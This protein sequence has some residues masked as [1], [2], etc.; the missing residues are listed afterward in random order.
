VVLVNKAHGRSTTP[1]PLPGLTLGFE[2]PGLS[3]IVDAG[4]RR[5]AELSDRAGA[6]VAEVTMAPDRKRTPA[7]PTDFYWSK[8]PHR[9][10][11]LLGA[12]FVALEEVAKG[13]YRRNRRRPL[14]AR[15]VAERARKRPRRR[16]L[17]AV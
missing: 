12:L 2:F 10:R 4:G 5:L 9:L 16:H 3:A 8:P 11:R 15:R 14:A 7:P 17:R 13:V 1:T 6:L